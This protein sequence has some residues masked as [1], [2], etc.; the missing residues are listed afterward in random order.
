MSN[1]IAINRRNE[2]ALLV[3]EK[4]SVTVSE[5]TK[6][7]DVSA[8]TIRKD[9]I[10]LEK[11]GVLIRGRGGAISS[12]NNIDL[13]IKT[14]LKENLKEKQEIAE[15][16]V[17]LLEKHSSVFIGA[18]STETMIAELLIKSD[19]YRI[20]TNSIMVAHYYCSTVNVHSK[21]SL[22]GG[23]IE[24]I[25]MATVGANTLDSI[26]NLYF[27]Y[28][29]LGTSGFE[30]MDGPS[31]FSYGELAIAKSVIQKSRKTII[32]GDSTKFTRTSQYMYSTWDEVDL[33][34]TNLD[35]RNEHLINDLNKKVKVVVA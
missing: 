35:H 31:T 27:D 3:T 20:F 18:G 9:L 30:K 28:S 1:L 6:I 12:D 10:F 19:G 16:T 33:L 29:V 21:L 5:L 7:F 13:P 24:E 23:E 11:R 15:K 25:S 34:V 17:T 8:E 14:K 26:N 2:L 4:K 22:L 32:I